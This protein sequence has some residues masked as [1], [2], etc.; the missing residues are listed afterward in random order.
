[1][2]SSSFASDFQHLYRMARSHNC[3]AAS[4]ACS[5]FAPISWNFN[6]SRNLNDKEAV[7]LASLLSRLDD[8]SLYP[9][10]KDKWVRAL[11]SSNIF[12]CRSFY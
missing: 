3:F 4:M 5:F 7:E 9:V 6:F 12:S 10:I 2:G 1:M 11:H 8:F